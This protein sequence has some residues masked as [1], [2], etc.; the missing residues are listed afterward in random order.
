[1]MALVTNDS[2]FSG[3][4]TLGSSLPHDWTEGTN[5]LPASGTIIVPNPSI[6]GQS[7][8]WLLIQNQSAVT[9][10]VG[11]QATT[12][13]GN[14]VTSNILIASGGAIGSQGG[15]QEFGLG[16]WKPNSAVTISGPV[17]SQL[18]V[19]EVLE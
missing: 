19:L 9:I 4:G 3:F 10:S 2:G 17:G 8:K 12:A 5:V 1:M 6:T 15:G 11:V 16:S 7:R 14:T 18:L 13:L